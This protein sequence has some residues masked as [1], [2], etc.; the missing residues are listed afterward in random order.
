MCRINSDRADANTPSRFPSILSTCSH[1]ESQWEHTQLS[2]IRGAT[3][4]ANPLRDANR[5]SS[6]TDAFHSSSRTNAS[7]GSSS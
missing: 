3:A 2:A 1:A 5:S 7:T 4:V 6:S